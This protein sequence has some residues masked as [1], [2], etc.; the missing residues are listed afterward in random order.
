MHTIYKYGLN[1][2]VGVTNALRRANNFNYNQSKLDNP[3]LYIWIIVTLISSTWKVIW[4]LRVSWGLFDRNAGKN[5]Y[6]REQILYPSKVFYYMAIIGDILFR[7]IWMINIFIQ[8]ESLSAEYSDMLG[9]TFGLIEIFRRFV[10]N[11][12]RLENEHLNN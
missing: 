3:F 4:D 2:I 11:F 6:L 5:K 10:W 12:F 7:Y 1:F 9:F 8:F